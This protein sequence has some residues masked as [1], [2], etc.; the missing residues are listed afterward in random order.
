MTRRYHASH[1]ER[2][3]HVSLD[4]AAG[5][6]HSLTI[7][8]EFD[9]HLSKGKQSEFR[10]GGRR[11]SRDD[12]R[13]EF[14]LGSC[15][16]RAKAVRTRVR[17]GR[18]ILLIPYWDSRALIPERREDPRETTGDNKQGASNLEPL[19]LNPPN[20]EEPFLKAD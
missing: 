4:E 6:T 10:L 7:L 13:G 17:L 16:G 5:A 19:D 12:G 1:V 9:V 8:L 18:F 3:D 14:A 2:R 15:I 11:P 20:R